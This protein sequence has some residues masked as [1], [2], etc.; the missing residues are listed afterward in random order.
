MGVESGCDMRL[1]LSLL[2]PAFR[3]SPSSQSE[4]V[5]L[6]PPIGRCPNRK[7]LFRP[8]QR[9]HAFFAATFKFFRF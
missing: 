1:G 7:E 8:N 6:R 2:A 4:K 3:S 9:T 5:R